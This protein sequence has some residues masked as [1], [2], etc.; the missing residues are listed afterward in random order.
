VRWATV[1]TK[2][3]LTLWEIKFDNQ[4]DPDDEIKEDFPN[5]E[6]DFCVMKMPT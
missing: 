3:N 2:G 4:C 5:T 6:V 1:G